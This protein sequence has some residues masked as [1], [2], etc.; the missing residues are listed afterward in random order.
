MASGQCSAEAKATA[1]REERRPR[2]SYSDDPSTTTV[3]RRTGTGADR[4]P[5][6]A[7]RRAFQMGF[8]A[9][10]L[11]LLMMLNKSMMP[12][13]CIRSPSLE[14][15]GDAQVIEEDIRRGAGVA[16][17]VADQHRHLAGDQCVGKAGR[18]QVAAGRVLGGNGHV[19]AGIGLTGMRDRGTIGAGARS[20]SSDRNRPRC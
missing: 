8:T 9:A 19:A 11:N 5:R 10:T 3:A 16:R 4:T 15:A 18:N 12:C 20:R 13:S 14:G 6:S 17:Q 1:P 7:L 2:R